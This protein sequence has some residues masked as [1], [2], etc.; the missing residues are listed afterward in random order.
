MKIALILLTLNEYDCLK[1]ILPRVLSNKIA[2]DIVYAIDGGSTDGTI[3]LYQEYNIPVIAQSKKGRGAAFHIARDTIDA[4]AFIFFSPDGNED[5]NDLVRFR[6]Q[7]EN[8]NDIVI[9]SRMMQGAINEEDDAIFKWRKW[10]NRTFNYAIHILFNRSDY[11]VTDSI[12]GYRAI[13]K[14]ALNQLALTANDYTIEFQ[15]TIRAFKNKLRITE[16]P[17]HEHPRIS[18]ETKAPSFKTGVRFMKRLW[19]E[20]FC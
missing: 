15:M 4:D 6:P 3:A 2:F 12:N 11:F 7:L 20:T 16:F 10:I 9:A 18:G 13:T 17:T 5:P 19:T 8:G 1:V 14:K